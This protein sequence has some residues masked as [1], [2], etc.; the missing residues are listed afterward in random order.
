LEAI[1]IILQELTAILSD[2]SRL[3]SPHQCISFASSKQIYNPIS[4]IATTS[5]NEA[6][7]REAVAFF[8]KLIESE[9]EEFLEEES[10]SWSLTNL[11]V[12]ITGANSTPIGSDTEV[13]IIELAFSI[14][15]KI[16][17]QPEILPTWFTTHSEVT[18]GE[19]RDA[20]EKFVGKTKKEDFPLFYLLI[21]YMHHEGRTGD[22]ARTGLL[23]LIET[24]STSTA[25]EQWV[26]ESDLA[27]QMASGLGA[28]YSRLSRK[29]VI[30][31]PPESLP[32]ILTLTDYQRPLTTTEIVSSADIDFQD[33]METFLSHLLFWQDVLEHCKSIE[34]KQTLLEHFQVIFLQQLLYASPYLF[35]NLLIYFRY[36]SLLESSDIDGGSSVAVLTYLRR[37]LECLDHPD[38]IH[39]IL[40]YLLALPDTPPA[41]D[42]VTRAVSA[43]RKRK[44]MDLA[45]MIAAQSELQS[46]PAL[47]NLVDLILGCLRSQSQQ[48]ITVTLQLVSVI[49][50]RHHRYAVT[51]LLRTSRTITVG[52]QRTIGAHEME[53]EYILSLAGEIGGEDNF[54]EV[55]E[56]HIKDSLSL[57]ESH[58]CSQKLIAPKSADGTSK[59]PSAQGSIPGGPRDMRPH[60]LRQ[61]DPMLETIL[62][63]LET[64][65]SNPVETN[66]CLTEA[67]VNLAA[68][69]FMSLEGWLLPDP[70]EYTYGNDDEPEPNLVFTTG[71]NNTSSEDFGRTQLYSV[72]QARRSPAWPPSQLPILLGHLR[73]LTSQISAY[74]TEIP[75][76]DDLLLQRRQ[77]FQSLPASRSGTPLP[78]HQ[79]SIAPP[80]SSFESSTSR[81][82]SPPPSKLSALDSFAQR[83]FPELTT[84]SRS[85]SPRGRREMD[86]KRVSSNGSYGI[87]ALTP[88]PIA[89]ATRGPGTGVPPPQFP[90]PNLEPANNQSSRAFSP[91]PLRGTPTP[92]QPATLKEIDRSI[93]ARKVGIPT[94]KEELKPV[95]LRSAAE[96]SGVDETSVI[97]EGDA[98]E[99]ISSSSGRARNEE[100]EK[101]GN[102]VSVSHVLTNVIVLQEFLLELAALVQVRAGLFGEVRFA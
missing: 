19:H 5:H 18:D 10:F 62:S 64:F 81:S 91:S 72:R 29:L 39:L 82:A 49:L 92:G 57:I 52:P 11:L 98:D 24:A 95:R 84:P 53:M 42:S 46:T 9:E 15:A 55:Y 22:F 40:H 34:V 100:D 14:A 54:D 48:T 73:A 87:A 27:T 51:T 86:R 99:N 88:G 38:M 12:R 43:A 79:I 31:C 80:R 69:G 90:M 25:L 71:L 67:I 3:P 58:P 75:R 13:E 94:R 2:E 45:A 41:G 83:I 44:S 20:H 76:F 60:T 36:P 26:V 77:A 35:L 97:S 7:I 63:V 4:K 47:F 56:N 59:L 50:K 96:S 1:R 101:K 102:L 37:I 85:S 30:D 33:H 78:T 93:L 32:P 68:C 89:N 74:R 66:L 16:R 21:D 8:S 70:S 17:L 6:I 61:D 65:F 23:Y 28:L